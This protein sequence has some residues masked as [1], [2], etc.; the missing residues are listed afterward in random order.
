MSG[1]WSGRGQRETGILLAGEWLAYMGH[2]RESY[3]Y[4]FSLAARTNPFD[5]NASPIVR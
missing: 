1:N 2:L 4:L 5:R 3:P